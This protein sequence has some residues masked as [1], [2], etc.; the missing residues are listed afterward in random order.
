M[1]QYPNPYQQPY[2]PPVYGPGYYAYDPFEPLL[3]PA[4]RASILMF[5][6]GGLLLLCGLCSGGMSAIDFRT[7]PGSSPDQLAELDRLE[8]QLG[9]PL[10]TLFIVS[11]LLTGVPGL[12]FLIL[13][14]FVRGGG[15]GAVISSLVLT[16]IVA[17]LQLLNL[18]FTGV[19]MAHDRSAATGACVAVIPLALLVLLSVWLIQAVRNAPKIADLR[20][21]GQGQYMHSMHQA[22]MYQQGGYYPQ[23]PP[24]PPQSPPPPE[25]P[26]Q[27]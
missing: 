27:V 23:Q 2:Q 13:G 24:P 8:Q 19:Q 16:V 3:R 22:Q 4:K 18:V 7:L 11:A 25:P 26:S 20:R 6:I 14:Y 9:I 10:R 21:G 1:S 17:L 15:M 5:I 12:L